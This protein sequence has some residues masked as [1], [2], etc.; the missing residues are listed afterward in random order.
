MFVSVCQRHQFESVQVPLARKRGWPTQIDWEG[1]RGRVCAMK[2]VLG[3]IMRDVDE[4]FVPGREKGAGA[5]EKAGR[6]EEDA[7]DD[8]ELLKTRPRMGSAF[9]KE[10]VKGVKNKGSRQASGVRGQMTSF[11][12]TQPG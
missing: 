3:A 8:L 11:S 9:W 2:E 5:D 10:V 4:A 6:D 12:K 7:V 1:L